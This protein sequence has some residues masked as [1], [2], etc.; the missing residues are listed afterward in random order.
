M[1][2]LTIRTAFFGDG[3][4]CLALEG[5][6]DGRTSAL[7]EKQVQELLERG[8]GRVAF[9][10]ERLSVMTSAG[11][12]VFVGAVVMAQERGGALAIIRPS[13]SVQQVFDVLG[14]GGLFPIEDTLQ[15]AAAK[16]RSMCSRAEGAV[17]GIP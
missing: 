14:L 7:L 5:D 3:L 1:M 16:I 12:G 2:G 15:A 9:D 8:S 4:V 6:L 10:L 17:A 11:A 13:P